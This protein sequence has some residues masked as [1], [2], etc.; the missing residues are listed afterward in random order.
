MPI[1]ILVAAI[2]SFISACAVAQT[3][4][5]PVADGRAIPGLIDQ[6]SARDLKT[7]GVSIHVDG[8][9]AWSEFHW[10]FRATMRKDKSAITTH[11]V[12][13]QVYRKKA[14]SWR[15][16]HVH[17]SADRQARPLNG[18]SV[19]SH[20]ADEKPRLSDLLL[21]EYWKHIVSHDKCRKTCRDSCNEKLR[22]QHPKENVRDR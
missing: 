12:E 16:V 21:A 18:R 5:G 10:K 7:N 14:G 19:V 22:F 8:D 4:T 13:T 17:Y 2:L 9:A 3:D 6:F 20:F 11:G 1:R 15:L